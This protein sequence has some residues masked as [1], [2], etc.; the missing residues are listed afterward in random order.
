MEI[1]TV[2]SGKM[3]K[4]KAS[5]TIFGM[6]RTNIKEF[7]KIIKEK[8]WVLIILLFYLFIREIFLEKRQ[9]I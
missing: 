8:A 5:D 6:I 2:A 1:I 4:E 7:G 3:I 9:Y